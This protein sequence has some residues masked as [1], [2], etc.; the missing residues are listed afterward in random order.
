MLPLSKWIP[1][2]SPALDEPLHLLPLVWMLERAASGEE[3]RSLTSGPPRFGKTELLKHFMA[4]TLK[5]DPTK[6]I[7][8]ASYSA[9]KAQRVMFDVGYLMMRTPGEDFEAGAVGFKMSQSGGGVRSVGVLGASLSGGADIVILDSM[10]KNW[11]EADNARHL[12]HV[13]QWVWDCVYPRLEGGASLVVVGERWGKNDLLGN[14][15]AS[16]PE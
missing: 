10:I 5:I 15:A 13:T 6:R 3:V 4:H 14:L 9:E 7:I 11:E 1:E 16:N 8:Y 2:V 12:E